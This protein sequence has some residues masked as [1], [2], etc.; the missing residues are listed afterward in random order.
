MQPSSTHA[1]QGADEPA[2]W[3]GTAR[4]EIVRRLGRGG[5]G[6]VYEAFDRERRQLVALTTLLHF[7]PAALYLFKQEFRT[8][9]DV[10]HE[11]LVHLFELEATDTGQVFF[12][13]ELLRGHDFRTYVEK[14]RVR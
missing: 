3:K 14:P 11:N 2:D 9:A 12:T 7:D 10:H 1:G 8:L 6:G 4:Y 13:M 5:M